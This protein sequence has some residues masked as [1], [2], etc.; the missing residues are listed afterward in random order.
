MKFN[1]TKHEITDL[2]EG[3]ELHRFLNGAEEPYSAIY[4]N[5]VEI[6][7]CDREKEREMLKIFMQHEGANVMPK[8]MELLQKNGHD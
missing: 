7:S 3:I 6:Y 5:S 2:S 4:I 8:I 1:D